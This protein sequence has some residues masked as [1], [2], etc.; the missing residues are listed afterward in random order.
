[1]EVQS[2]E[3][4]RALCEQ[5]RAEIA[6]T[7][8]EHGPLFEQLQGR[9]EPFW[10]HAVIGKVYERRRPPL[11]LRILALGE[12]AAR[13]ALYPH[14][15][16]NH[17]LMELVRGKVHVEFLV[18]TL[19]Y[20]GKLVPVKRLGFALGNGEPRIDRYY[21]KSISEDLG[22]ML[23]AVVAFVS[24]P[25]AA[26]RRSSNHCCICGKP[27]TDGT[28]RSR[29]IGP[30]CLSKTTFFRGSEEHWDAQ[31]EAESVHMVPEP[32]PLEELEDVPQL[33]GRESV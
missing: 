28:S 5:K 24:D 31:L 22:R 3:E 33:T 32:A 20:S 29:G 9:V 14:W 10:E 6:T 19:R 1:M 23:E 16:N 15:L 18:M 17:G 13:V 21:P 25:L 27:L 4:W 26:F 12:P 7:L 11:G 8:A 30:E 2:K